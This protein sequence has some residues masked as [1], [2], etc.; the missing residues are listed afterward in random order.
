MAMEVS[1]GSMMSS[2]ESKELNHLGLVAGMYDELGIGKSIDALIPQD[3]HQ[4]NIS[5]GQTLKAMVLNGL[6]FSNRCLYLMPHFFTGKP[7]EHLLGEGVTASDL[8]DDV[9][10]RMLDSIYEAG[11]SDLY[12]VIAKNALQRLG[13]SCHMSHIDTTTFHTD[14]QYNHADEEGVI[15]ITKGYSRDHRPELNQF[16]LKLIVEGQAGIPMMMEALSGNDNDKTRFRE[17]IRDHIGQLQ[18]DF[19][20]QHLLGDSALYCAKTLKLMQGLIWT[21]RVPETLSQAR[22]LIEE[23]AD[24]LA[25]KND[26]EQPNF[27]SIDVTY[28]EIE[29]QWIVVYSPQANARAKHSVSKQ[30]EK[31]SLADQ[32]LFD[33]LCKQEFA[34]KEDA[35]KAAETLQKKLKTSLLHDLHAEPIAGFKKRGRPAKNA[36]PDYFTYRICGTLASDYLQYQQRLK[37]KS[38]FILA[39]NQTDKTLIDGHQMLADYKN[40]QKVE[41]GFRFL[42]DPMFLASTVFLKS[43]KRIMALTMVMTVCL[44]VYAALEHRMRKALLDSDSSLPNQTGKMINNPSIRWVFQYFQNIPVIYLQQTKNAVL[45]VNNHHKKL[46]QLMGKSYIR[47][48]S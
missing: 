28:A 29:Q 43:P 26:G 15:K 31:K 3:M 9:T 12:R 4:R 38:C 41:R 22:E 44:L 19:S 46:L 40:Q 20:T 5:I 2:C 14:G 17:T 32:R 21:S 33:G 8:N 1:T 18:D 27:K 34:C 30:Y 37:R 39:T 47:L 48:Y 6:G 25:R 13:L 10:G 36:E 16:G 23:L 7:V 42:K 11:G 45:N 24:G 35:L